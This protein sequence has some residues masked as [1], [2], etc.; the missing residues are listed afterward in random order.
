MLH[1]FP[2]GEWQLDA[3][4]VEALARDIVGG[5]IAMS[6]TYRPSMQVGLP[7]ALLTAPA[8]ALA[9]WFKV[10]PSGRKIPKHLHEIL[11]LNQGP[12]GP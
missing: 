11:P 8:L 7:L 5:K 2:P 3:Y 4:S 1:A 12:S 10:V 9:M 6:L